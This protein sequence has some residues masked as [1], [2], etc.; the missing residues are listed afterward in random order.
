MLSAKANTPGALELVRMAL[1][2][3]SARRPTI[4]AG[5]KQHFNK[6][7]REAKLLRDQP[8]CLGERPEPESIELAFLMMETGDLNREIDVIDDFDAITPALAN[9]LLAGID[10]DT[11]CLDQSLPAS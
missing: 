2:M 9:K 10:R 7:V 5:L 6:V 4:P 11:V 1:I 8:D 3:A